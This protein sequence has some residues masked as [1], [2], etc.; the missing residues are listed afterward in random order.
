MSAAEQLAHMRGVLERTATV[1][2]N[3]PDTSQPTAGCPACA[4]PRPQAHD[5]R[6]GIS[7]CAACNP[8]R[9]RCGIPDCPICPTSPT[10]AKDQP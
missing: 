9:A 7:R 6:R 1:T 2:H 3:H 5:H 10:T 8:H 4:L